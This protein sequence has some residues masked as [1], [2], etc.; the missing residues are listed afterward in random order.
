MQRLEVKSAFG[1]D[2]T[3]AI[4]GN[5]WVFGTAD[6]MG[7]IIRKGAFISPSHLPM[8]FA[9]DPAEPIG[10]WDAI[11]ETAEGLQ[12]KGRLLVDAVAR[13]KEVRALVQSKAITG[14][15]IGY[16]VKQAT[17]RKGGGRDIKSL[18]LV[19]IS[20]V[21]IPMHPGARVTSAKSATELF[22]IAEAINR[23]AAAFRT[24]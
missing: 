16:S 21:T 10:V 24:T 7:D 3:G 11:T 22:A 18:E 15:S 1:V 17:G 6:R 13:A 19:E 23:A 20:L 4:T 14:L 2:D 8:L 12:V 5:A 9:H